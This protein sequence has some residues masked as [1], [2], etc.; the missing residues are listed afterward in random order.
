MLLPYKEG[1][2]MAELLEKDRREQIFVRLRQL[3]DE[4]QAA[5]RQGTEIAE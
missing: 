2:R 3:R 5:D 1:K 4:V